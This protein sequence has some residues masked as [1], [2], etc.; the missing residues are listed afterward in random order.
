[1]PR[2]IESIFTY[3]RWVT[4]ARG[5]SIT[6]KGAQQRQQI[7]RWFDYA[8]MKAGIERHVIKRRVTL[9]ADPLFIPI[10]PFLS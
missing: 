9:D 10:G 4:S 5:I 7:C 1:M 3:F 6:C 8:A 2:G